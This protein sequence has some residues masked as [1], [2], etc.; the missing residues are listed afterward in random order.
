MRCQLTLQPL[1]SSKPAGA[2]AWSVCPRRYPV[3]RRSRSI[4]AKTC[5]PIAPQS[6]RSRTRPVLRSFAKFHAHVYAAFHAFRV[7]RTLPVPLVHRVPR[8]LAAVLHVLD[9]R[10]TSAG[11]AEELEFP[12]FS[13]AIASFVEGSRVSRRHLRQ[14]V[15]DGQQ[16]FSGGGGTCAQLTMI[17]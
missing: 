4:T 6:L 16:S 11:D 3:R 2:T 10:E 9:L 15:R 8:P 14:A 5:Q 17:P 7:S 13:I 1:L 12:H